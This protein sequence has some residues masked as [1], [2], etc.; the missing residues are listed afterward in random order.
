MAAAGMIAVTPVASVVPDVQVPEIQLVAADGFAADLHGWLTD[1]GTDSISR[2]LSANK[3]LLDTEMGFQEA[4]FKLM[5][6]LGY[7][8]PLGSDSIFA[9]S[10]NRGF[11]SFNMLLDSGEQ[12]LRGVL[13][14]GG[15]EAGPLA[16]T[17]SLLHGTDPTW[18]LNTGEVGGLIGSFN[19]GFKVIDN[20]TGIPGEGLLENLFELEKSLINEG[21]VNGIKDFNE[22]LTV[23][24]RGLEEFV[25]PL[26]KLVS[27]LLGDSELI[28]K[29]PDSILNG[30]VNRAFNTFNMFL[31]AG[32][33]GFL[34]MLGADF[35]PTKMT[36]SLL[37]GVG[38]LDSGVFNSGD[39]GGLAGVLGQ[40]YMTL[41]DL[42][43]LVAGLNPLNFLGDVFG[44]FNPLDY[45]L[46]VLGSM[47]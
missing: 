5:A 23:G 1:Y 9:G 37:I 32:Q 22:L 31:D 20:L 7:E 19:Q 3:G 12:G 29:A 13:G 39:I 27:G 14:V 33:Q 45:L 21:L 41:A 24:E 42:G 38:A 8:D 47:F 35:D 10:L 46:A 44:D 25:S 34:G 15:A 30:V 18:P 2:L 26:F 17:Q 36:E 40:G 16:I 43:G 11:N 6:T 4:V 28:Y